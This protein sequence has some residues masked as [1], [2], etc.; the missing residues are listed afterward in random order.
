MTWTCPPIRSG[1][2]PTA[3]RHVHHVHPGHHLE[4]LSGDM[5]GSNSRRR[6]IELARMGF[7]EGDKLGT[8][9]TGKELLTFRT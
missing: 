5:P 7:G 9:F 3:V 8:V 1:T 2:A 6:H 4:H